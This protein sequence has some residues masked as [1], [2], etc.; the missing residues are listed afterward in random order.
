MNRSRLA[1]LA[2]VAEVI[3]A[4]AVVI[5]L[6]YVGI[7]VNENTSAVKAA[8]IQE[9][10]ASTREILIGVASNAELSRITRLGTVD[11]AVLTDDEAWRFTLFSRQRWLFFQGIWVQRELGVVDDDLWRAY[12]V[13]ICGTNKSAGNRQ[14]WPNH[15]AILDPR[16]VDWVEKCSK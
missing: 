5:S 6:I 8:S 13:I 1:E 3:A 16:F 15:T 10:T 11:R 2:Q 9:I 12:Q 4:V 7:E 14:E